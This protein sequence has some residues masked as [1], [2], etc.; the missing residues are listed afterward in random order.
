[1]LLLRTLCDRWLLLENED[2]AEH[3][4]WLIEQLAAAEAAGEAVHLL[5]HIPPGSGDCD[6]TW[7]HV[8]NAI[9]AR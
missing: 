7:S 5:G 2:P 6:R 8:L 9:I 4:Q 3:L 1:M